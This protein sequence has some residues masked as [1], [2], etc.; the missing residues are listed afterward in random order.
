MS[1]VWDSSSQSGGNLLILLAL[2]DFAN[3][4]GECWPAISTLAAKARMTERHVRRILRD[5]EAAGEIESMPGG[6]QHGTNRYLVRPKMSGED[7]MSGG[8]FE[9]APLTLVSGGEDMGVSRSVIEPSEEPSKPQK[10]DEL[11]LEANRFVVWFIELL[12]ETGAKITDPTPSVRAMWADTYRLLVERDGKKKQDIVAVCRWAR[13]DQF[14]AQNFMSPAKLRT[15][16]EGISY[17]DRFHTR[18]E[19]PNANQTA[20]PTNSRL[21]EQAGLDE[22]REYE[23]RQMATG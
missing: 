19:N 10:A 1:A 21:Y 2:A 8:H 7:K 17:F 13:N 20:R 16:K 12:A 9:Q 3:D 4:E 18:M 22:I 5:L 6:G 15:K 11:S 14:W 23:R